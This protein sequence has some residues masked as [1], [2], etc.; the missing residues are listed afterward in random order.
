MGTGGCLAHGNELQVLERGRVQSRSVY[1]RMRIM[2]W[3]KRPW[4]I[5]EDECP[6]P[7][8]CLFRTLSIFGYEQSYGLQAKFVT[9][10][11]KHIK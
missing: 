3:E 5:I 9:P 7:L 8:K 4:S 11:H 1:S 2:D 10:D 6:V